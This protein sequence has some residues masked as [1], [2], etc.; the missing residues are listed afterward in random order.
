MNSVEE[1]LKYNQ[2]FVE[3]KGYEKYKASKFPE[4]KICIVSCM[5]TRLVSLLPNALGIKDGDVKMVKNAGGVVVHPFGSAMRSILV[6]IYEFGVEAVIIIGHDNCGMATVDKSHVIDNMFAAGVKKETFDTLE[7]AGIKINKWLSGFARV[8]DSVKQS[9]ELV[10][11]HPLLPETI[12]VVG[13]IMDPE[14]G[15]VRQIEEN[16]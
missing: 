10:K 3:N 11:R 12:N 16:E 4:R 15:E 8:E 6:A 1:I 7:N 2:E 14:T 5:D 13:L 9:V